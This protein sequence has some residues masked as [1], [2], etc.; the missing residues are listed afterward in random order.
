MVDPTG[1]GDAFAAGYLA[2]LMRGEDDEACA[3]S[4]LRAAAQAVGRP[5]ARPRPHSPSRPTGASPA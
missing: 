5:G 1:A 2:A 4:A 3:H